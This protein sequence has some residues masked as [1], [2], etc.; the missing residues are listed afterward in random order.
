[1]EQREIESIF[2]KK[3]KIQ[4]EKEKI[5]EKYIFKKKNKKYKKRIIGLII[6]K[7]GNILKKIKRKF[8]NIIKI[9][10]Q[11]IFLYGYYDELFEIKEL[12]SKIEYGTNLNRI[13]KK[14]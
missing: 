8:G 10:F 1:M 12:I 2:L 5:L 13:I 7:K 14:I 9:N 6:G 11:K 3:L 4:K